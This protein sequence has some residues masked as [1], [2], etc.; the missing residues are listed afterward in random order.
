MRGVLELWL[1]DALEEFYITSRFLG[2]KMQKIN[3]L[4]KISV[5]SAVFSELK[6]T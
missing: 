2:S 4:K 6:C 5:L 1:N 3:F